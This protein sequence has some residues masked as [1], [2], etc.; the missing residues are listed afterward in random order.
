MAET[1]FGFGEDSLAKACKDLPWAK[2]TGSIMDP[3][4][5]RPGR[6]VDRTGARP[7]F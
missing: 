6:L 1:T 5:R 2:T 7:M 4:Y 3:V